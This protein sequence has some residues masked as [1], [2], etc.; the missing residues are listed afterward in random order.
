MSGLADQIK[1]LQ[2]TDPAAKQA[3]SEFCD[4]RPG[5]VKDPSKHDEGVLNEFITLYQSGAIRPAGNGAALGGNGKGAG[6]GGGAAWGQAAMGGWAPP[7][8]KGG[9]AGPCGKGGGVPGGCGAPAWSVGEFVKEGQRRSQSWRGAWEKYCAVFGTGYNDPAKYEESFLIQFINYAGELAY[10]DLDVQAA[11]QGV[12]LEGKGGGLKRPAGATAWKPAAKR[13]ATEGKPYGSTWTGGS[14]DPERHELIAQVK[15]M[16]KL[17][18]EMK[19]AWWKYCEDNL[20]G[21]KDP[22]RHGI[23]ELRTF[24]EAYASAGVGM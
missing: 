16:Q 22:S 11:E 4:T 20:G 17:S 5:R 8:G 1:N 9:K 15:N 6:F 2:R 10:N 19:Q 14:D 21:T 18:P 7:C 12:N 3:W 13:A 24:I 23:P